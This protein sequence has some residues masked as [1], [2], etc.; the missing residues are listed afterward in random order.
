MMT[1]KMVNIIVILIII[2]KKEFLVEH[3]LFSTMPRVK[4]NPNYYDS[5]ESYVALK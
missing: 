2:I 3:E 4:P 5:Q 1:M